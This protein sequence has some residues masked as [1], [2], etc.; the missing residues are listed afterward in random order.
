[1]Q[2]NTETEEKISLGNTEAQFAH[3]VGWKV[4][5]ARGK[6]PDYPSKFQTIGRG[7]LLPFLFLNECQL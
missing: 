6:L 7:S 5:Q 3:H 2:N 1:M 4:I